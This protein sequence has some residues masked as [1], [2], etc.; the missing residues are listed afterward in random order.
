MRGVKMY[1]LLALVD[2]LYYGEANV[3][4]EN[5]ED[6]LVVAE[7]LQLKGLSGENEEPFETKVDENIKMEEPNPVKTKTIHSNNTL[8]DFK[9]TQGFSEE[10]VSGYSA[11]VDIEGLDAKIESMMIKTDSGMARHGNQK[12]AKC[13]ICGKEDRRSHLKEHIEANHIE[14]ISH[15]CNICGKASRSGHNHIIEIITFIIIQI[16]I[17]FLF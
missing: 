9:L 8:A 12:Q 17:C 3:Y 2:F 7:E 1:N 11:S 5:L 14:G 13:T 6:F 10:S 16:A 15:I 4:Q